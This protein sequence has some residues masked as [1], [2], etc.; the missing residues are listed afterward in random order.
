MFFVDGSDDVTRASRVTAIKMPTCELEAA[1]CKLWATENTWRIVNDAMQIRGGRGYE[2]ARVI[3]IA[4]RGGQLRWSGCCATARI[5]HDN[6]KAP[7]LN[8]AAFPRA[9]RR[10]TRNLKIGGRV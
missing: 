2:T 7:A 10:W 9:R 6:L 1:M 4:R 8:H 5:K 3:E